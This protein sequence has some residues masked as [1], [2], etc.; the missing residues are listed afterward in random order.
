[1]QLNP[2]MADRWSCLVLLIHNCGTMSDIKLILGR[3]TVY[4]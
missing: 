4:T 3:H 2:A 1:M